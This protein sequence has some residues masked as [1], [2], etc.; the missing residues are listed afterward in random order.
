M[1]CKRRA[2][3]FSLTYLA[4][5]FCKLLTLIFFFL[6]EMLSVT[7]DITVSLTSMGAL[8]NLIGGFTSLNL[9]GIDMDFGSLS[10]SMFENYNQ[11]LPL[12]FRA[13][14][15]WVANISGWFSEAFID[16]DLIFYDVRFVLFCRE[17]CHSHHV[18]LT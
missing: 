3:W 12:S 8:S 9:I 6:I 14:F 10:V 11:L 17:T 5:S 18:L 15:G 4:D 16:L 13:L 1:C 7:F 2:F